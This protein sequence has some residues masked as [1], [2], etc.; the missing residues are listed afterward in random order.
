L[1]TAIEKIQI[2]KKEDNKIKENL[3]LSNPDSQGKMAM[4]SF[5]CKM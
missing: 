2:K 4:L 3:M 1:H 5:I